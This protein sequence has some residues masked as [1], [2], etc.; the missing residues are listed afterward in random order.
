[1]NGWKQKMSCDMGMTTR[2]KDEGLKGSPQKPE[3]TTWPPAPQTQILRSIP[4]PPTPTRKLLRNLS[5]KKTSLA[6][7]KNQKKIKESTK[8]TPN[9]RYCKKKNKSTRLE[10]FF[11]PEIMNIKSKPIATVT[12][13]PKVKTQPGSLSRQL[14]RSRKHT[15]MRNKTLAR[16][17][18]KGQPRHTT[19]K[20]THRREPNEP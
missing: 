5:Q 19:Q 12:N 9:T 8:K 20:T 1:M 13:A 17:K 3:I 10:E 7:Q 11:Q 16:E 14:S 15:T 6:N 4:S 2:D 18:K